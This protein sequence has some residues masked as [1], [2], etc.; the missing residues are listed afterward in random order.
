[1]VQTVSDTVATQEALW[2]TM[3]RRAP[4][5]AEAISRVDEQTSSTPAL[6]TTA[7]FRAVE[8][9]SMAEA[10]Y[11]RDASLAA[12]YLRDAVQED[13]AFASAQALLAWTPYRG[14]SP[15]SEYLKF[16]ARAAQQSDA[17]SEPERHFILGTQYHLLALSGERTDVVSLVEQASA[18]YE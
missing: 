7:S 1:I 9:Y 15:S 2:K 11:D 16:A 14:G 13:P 8:L 10:A 18:E 5:I 17:T 3:R 4:A 6:V 12:R